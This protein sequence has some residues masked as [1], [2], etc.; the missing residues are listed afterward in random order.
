M[1]IKSAPILLLWFLLITCEGNSQ[2]PIPENLNFLMAP[3]ANLKIVTDEDIITGAEQ[4]ATLKEA[5]QFKKVGLIANHTSLIDTTHLVDSM[6]KAGINV[7][8][9]FSPEHGF[10]GK[11]DA[12]ELVSSKKDT[13]TGLPLISLY[14]QNKKPKLSDL[15]EIDA[16]VFDL[17]DVGV[18]FYTYISTLYYAM[19]ACAE[20]GIPLYVLDRPNPNG[21]YVDGPVLKEDFKSFVGVAKIPVVYGLTI[22]EFAKMVNEEGWLYNDLKCNL[23][24]V[25]LKGYQHNYLYQLPVKPS[26]NLPNMTSVYL[27]PSLCFFEGTV[28][29]VGRGTNLPF[30][31][32]GHP[33]MS[34]DYTFTPDPTE[35]ASAPKLEG[36][37]CRGKSLENFDIKQSFPTF[38][39]LNYLM[40]AYK[41]L[42]LG[43]EFFL[44]NKFIN[45]L[46]G[47]DQLR[48]QLLEG[49]NMQAI[50]DSWEPE[51]SEFRATRKNYLLYPEY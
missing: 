44:K 24:V 33:R 18:R 17:Q 27:Y 47:T 36:E 9:I 20:A 41:D 23:T 45:L 35:G 29:S 46:A 8:K 37:F 22:G 40:E 32:Y 15:L 51:L 31:I 28:V 14:G 48:N 10:R 21:F 39:T 5:L 2:L 49:K 50:R 1:S 34:G 19:E 12:G 6:L 26:P 43:E 13:K 3:A 30:Q 42:D 16:I 4:V 11:Y 38:F 25:P 7:T